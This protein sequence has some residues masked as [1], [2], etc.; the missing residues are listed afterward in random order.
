MQ[1]SVDVIVNGA[2]PVGLFCAYMLIKDGLSVYL[3]DKKDGPTEQSRALGISP[4][5]LE[6][7]QHHGIGYRFLQDSIVVRGGYLHVNG[8]D[9]RNRTKR[10][11]L[12]TDTV[13]LSSFIDGY[14]TFP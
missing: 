10:S 3:A 5:S 12:L 13:S 8:Y 2:G 6:V 1:Q 11:C 4:R 9:V 14:G 7:L